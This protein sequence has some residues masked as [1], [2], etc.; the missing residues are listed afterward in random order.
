MSYDSIRMSLWCYIVACSNTEDDMSCDD[1]QASGDCTTDMLTMSVN[2][3][4]T[5]WHCDYTGKYTH[6]SYIMLHFILFKKKSFI[7]FVLYLAVQWYFSRTWSCLQKSIF[8]NCDILLLRLCII[9]IL[10]YSGYACMSIY[11]LSHPNFLCISTQM[12]I[13]SHKQM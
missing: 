8:L 7:V 1:R 3:R 5:C 12:L 13:G 2:C 4:Q 9:R 11:W 10:H 6:S